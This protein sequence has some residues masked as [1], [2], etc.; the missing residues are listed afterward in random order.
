MRFTLWALLGYHGLLAAAT[1]PLI[2]ASGGAVGTVDLRVA[3]PSG[4]ANQ[5]LPLRTI[6]RLEE[7]DIV[8]YQPVLRAR[9][10]RKG[11]VTMVLVPA[12]KKASGQSK[13]LIFDPRSAGRPQ[14][15]KVPWR[16]SLVAFVYGPSGLNVKKVQSFLDTDDEL[17]GELADYADKTEKTEALIAALTSSDN[18]R[19]SVSAALHGFSSQ[20]GSSSGTGLGTGS[21]LTKGTSLNQQSMTMITV[22]NPTIA[23]YDPIAGEGARPVGQTAGLAST[24]G[25][26]FFGDPIGLAAGG[27]AVLLN[28][29][30]M[31]FPK[32][33]FRSMFSQAMPDQAMGLCGKTGDIPVHTR[34]A[35]L[36]ASRIPNTNAPKFLVGNANSLPA[37]LKSPLPLLGSKDA[38][39]FVDRARDWMLTPETGKPIPVKVHILADTHSVELALDKNVKPGNY[40]LSAKWDWDDLK[41][42]GSIDVRPVSDFAQAKLTELAQARLVAGK[43]KVPLTLEG[44]DFEFVTRAQIKKL[45]DEFAS[46]NTVPFVLP[47]GLRDGVQDHMDIQADTSDLDAGNYELILSQVDG[48]SHDVPL[49]VLPPPPVI[50]NLPITVNQDVSTITFDLKG[51]RLNLLRHLELAKGTAL[52][53]KASADGTD[54]EVTVKLK[55][56]IVAGTTLAIRASVAN[57]IDPLT[58]EDGVHVGPSLPAISG[59]TISQLPAQAI[60]LAPGELPGA[61]TL[62]AMLRVSH[63]ATGSSLHLECEQTST[64]A[65]TLQ[66]GEPGKDARLEQ[67]TPGEL[68]VTFSTGAW[69]NGCRMQASVIGSTGNSEPHLIGTIV[70]VPTIE[71]FDVAPE[72]TGDQVDAMLTGHHLE[73]IQKTGWAPDQGTPVS[74]LPQPM[75]SDGLEQKLDLQLPMPPTPDAVLY[76]WLRGENK[77]RVTTVRA[78]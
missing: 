67:L 33:Q 17:I 32:T 7:G 69:I 10:A 71:Q 31:A 30:A 55:P 41:V 26:M 53:G 42:T 78:N 48:K 52:L 22:I 19:E 13:F 5:A 36:W 50:D 77:A 59:V 61:S 57:H 68:F 54:R 1:P 35:Y 21:G 66:P 60:Q 47:K 2:C 29:Q 39:K 65:I 72:G 76:V 56:G 23:N 11:D 9:E 44:C 14:H 12:N 58:F 34:L 4:K 27:T 6:T 28:L 24:V 20:F 45:N 3:S 46:A 38:W 73:T 16:T 75:S 37:D 74:T 15:W 8:Q 40:T 62:S 70:D 64:G 49:T 25:Q 51:K 18:S 63:L 43:G